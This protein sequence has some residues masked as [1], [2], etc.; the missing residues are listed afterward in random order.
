MIEGVFTPTQKQD[1]IRKL[2]DT[3]VAIEP[4]DLVRRRLGSGFAK[5]DFPLVG[6]GVIRTLFKNYTIGSAGRART[7]NP[8][9]NSRKL[10]W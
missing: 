9:V 3:M 2:T 1:M 6:R 8:P 4:V 5:K 7:D 10:G